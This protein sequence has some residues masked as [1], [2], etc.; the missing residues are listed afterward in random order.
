[1]AELR[2]EL[3]RTVI[4]NNA[5][6]IA[7]V[8]SAEL[9]P[10]RARRCT[11]TTTDDRI[12]VDL[13]SGE[14]DDVRTAWAAVVHLSALWPDVMPSG[15][16]G[17]EVTVNGATFTTSGGGMDDVLLGCDYVTWWRRNGQAH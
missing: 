12:L 1:M 10:Q 11:V 8:L 17:L 16:I 14:L 3:W 4:D 9:G 15:R 13:D 2:A 6:A 7:D 5:A